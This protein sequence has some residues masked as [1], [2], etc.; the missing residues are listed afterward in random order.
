MIISNQEIGRSNEENVNEGKARTDCV[1]TN[2]SKECSVAAKSEPKLNAQKAVPAVVSTG[3][4]HKST[5]HHQQQQVQKSPAIRRKVNITKQKTPV[6]A[7]VAPKQPPPQ[8]IINRARGTL[9]GLSTIK[10]HGNVRVTPTPEYLSV[11]SNFV[12]GPL[13][14]KVEKSFGRG[15]KRETKRATATTTQMIGRINL[16]IINDRATL[17]SIKVQQPKQVKFAFIWN[18]DGE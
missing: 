12:L 16:R 3:I 6:K 4:K 8:Q 11:R 2:Q 7:E 5:A 17:H 15:G 14:L 18:G 13:V 1:G 9:H 10:R